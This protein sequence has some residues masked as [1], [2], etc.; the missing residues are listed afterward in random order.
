MALRATTY[1]ITFDITMRWKP[2][3][4]EDPLMTEQ[5]DINEIDTIAYISEESDNEPFNMAMIKLL[6]CT[7]MMTN[8]VCNI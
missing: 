1:S 2:F 3:D 4:D 8:T 7:K 5:E 6:Y